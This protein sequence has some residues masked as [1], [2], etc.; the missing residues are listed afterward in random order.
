MDGDPYQEE[1]GDESE[2]GDKVDVAKIKDVDWAY[3]DRKAIRKAKEAYQK[4]KPLFDAIHSGADY[5]AFIQA[6]RE[7]TTQKEDRWFWGWDLASLLWDLGLRDQEAEKNLPRE[8]RSF[9][10]R[11]DQIPVSEDE[12][13]KR[14]RWRWEFGTYAVLETDGKWIA[15]G[16]MGWF[17]C[18]SDTPEE[19]QDWDRSF[20]EGF[21]RD[22]DPEV[23]VAIVD[24]H[25]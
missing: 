18:S 8:D 17:G 22:E 24:C 3:Y 14:F 6:K 4:L 10:I 12:F 1:E 15:K 5:N 16:E 13:V 20:Y 11:T 7:K 23:S 9:I 19:G 25:I 2:T 21:I